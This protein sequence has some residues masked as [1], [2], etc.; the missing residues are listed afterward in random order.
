MYLGLSV[1]LT[2]P[3]LFNQELFGEIAD[4]KVTNPLVLLYINLSLTLLLP[5]VLLANRIVYRVSTGYSVSVTGRL[6][7]GWLVRTTLVLVPVWLGFFFVAG[8]VVPSES[9]P[10]APPLENWGLLLLVIV[11]TTPLQ[12]AGE[13]FAFRSWIAQ[14]VGSYFRDGKLAVIAATL[15]SG[16]AFALAHGSLDP[17]ILLDLFGMTSLSTWAL[18]RTGG[19]EASLAIHTVNN[20]LLMCIT[21]LTGGFED[22]F[23]GSDSSSSPRSAAIGLGLYLACGLAIELMARSNR[24]QRFYLPPV[25]PTPIQQLLSFPVVE[26]RGFR[27]LP[28]NGQVPTG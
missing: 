28:P 13:E 18:W 12:C 23:I 6:R 24:I 10:T 11:T 17:W 3:F 14:N 26:I 21:V 1:L 27:E 9:A 20:V 22:S 19:L 16:S 8:M 2:V 4:A 15:V 25:L 5:S 7:W